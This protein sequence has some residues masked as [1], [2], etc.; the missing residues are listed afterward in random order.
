MLRI[1]VF[2][3]FRFHQKQQI[4]DAIVI[5]SGIC[6]W[7]WLMT[8]VVVLSLGAMAFAKSAK[9]EGQIKTHNGDSLVIQTSSSPTV[10]VL[11]E[12]GTRSR[13]STES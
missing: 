4:A 9:L 11:L 7:K 13:R 6:K 1:I 10:T 12:D 2:T 8:T 3:E 5:S